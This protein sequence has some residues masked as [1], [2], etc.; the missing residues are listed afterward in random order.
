[1]IKIKNPKQ[2][3]LCAASVGNGYVSAIGAWNF[4][5]V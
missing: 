3:N 4:D 1:M 5:I 2:K